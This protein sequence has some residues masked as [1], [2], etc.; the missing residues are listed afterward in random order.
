MKRMTV[1][2]V[3]FLMGMAPMASA[4]P[5][6]A[7]GAVKEAGCHVVTKAQPRHSC[8][9]ADCKCTVETQSNNPSSVI[10]ASV[11]SRIEISSDLPALSVVMAYEA[12]RPGLFFADSSPPKVLPLYCLYSAYLL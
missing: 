11:P 2:L 12:G 5:T 8:C 9:G 4:L 6:D 10:P 3:V 1:F 7:C